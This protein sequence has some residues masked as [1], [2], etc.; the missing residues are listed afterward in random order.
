MQEARVLLGVTGGIAAYKA[1]ELVRLLVKGGAA[2]RVFMTAHACRFVTPLT[3]EV[4]TG[5]PVGVDLFAPRGDAAVGHVEAAAWCDLFCVAPATANVIGKLASGIA[6]D[7]LTTTALALPGDTPR[8]LAPA[9][10][11]RMWAN[12]LV[13]RNLR[14]LEDPQGGGWRTVPPVRKELACGT[15]GV[16]GLADPEEI[17]KALG[18][19]LRVPP[20][21]DKE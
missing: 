4:L 3:F 19:V 12:T 16:G 17:V 10:N 14:L 1:C 21:N 15:F 20:K 8:V 6:D 11:E 9:M 13:Q 2:V 18:A 5:R 7:L